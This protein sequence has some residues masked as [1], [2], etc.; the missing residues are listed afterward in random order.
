MHVKLV[1]ES[2]ALNPRTSGNL[3]WY[4]WRLGGREGGRERG[5]MEK[6]GRH[7]HSSQDPLFLNGFFI[8]S[9]RQRFCCVKGP[10]TH[11]R[12][13]SST[14]GWVLSS[15]RCAALPAVARKQ[16]ETRPQPQTKTDRSIRPVA[17]EM[18]PCVGTALRPAHTLTPDTVTQTPVISCCLVTCN[19]LLQWASFSNAVC[20]A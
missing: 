8:H 6:E 18:S 14:R 10:M 20:E 1:D 5:V 4:I 9:G 2:P 13:Q 7:V 15:R 16:L 11:T 17:M 3:K 19:I 12:S